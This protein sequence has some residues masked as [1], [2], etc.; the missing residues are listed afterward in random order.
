MCYG[1]AWIVDVSVS[2]SLLEGCSQDLSAGEPRLGV[3]PSVGDSDAITTRVVS[4]EISVFSGCCPFSLK[5]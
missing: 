1:P 5:L 3:D 4:V 2:G